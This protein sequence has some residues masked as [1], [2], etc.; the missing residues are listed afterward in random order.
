VE[1]LQA[2]PSHASSKGSG[3]AEPGA[4]EPGVAEPGV[5]EPGLAEHGVAEH[6]ARGH[7]A[8]G[9]SASGHSVVEAG[10]SEHSEAEAGSA[11]RPCRSG[12]GAG[13]GAKRSSALLLAVP[14]AAALAVAS[15]PPAAASVVPNGRAMTANVAAPPRVAASTE[16]AS[17]EVASTEVAST[18]VGSTEVA[19]TEVGSAVAAS[20]C[21]LPV[22]S[23]PYDGFKVGVPGGWDVSSLQ[24]LIG[25]TA[26]AA[27]TEGALLYPALLTSGVTTHSL[28]SSF[29][30]YEDK[31]LGKQ[32]ASLTYSEHP[33]AQP[34]ASL[35]IRAGGTVLAGR[36]GVLVL[37]LRTQVTDKLG[38]AYAYWAPQAQLAAAAPTLSEIASCYQPEQ[39][40][41]FQLFRNVGAFTFTMPPGWR[42]SSLNQNFIQL[43]G[44]GTGAGVT[45][46]LWGPFEQGVNATQPIT[47]VGSA[48]SYMFNLYGIKVNQ[49]LSSYVLPGQATEYMEFVG[50]LNGKAIHGIVNMVASIDGPSAAGVI[51]LGLATPALWNSVN[52]GLVQMMG[53]I[54]HNFSGDLQQIAQLNRQ[55]QD[56][57]GQVSDFD[58]ILN[59][60][61]LVQDPTNG[62]LY[63]APYSAWD[64]EGPNGPGYYLANG[65]QL[66]PVQRP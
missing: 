39:A 2:T 52:G 42:V 65:Q 48:I 4:A 45:Y 20:N 17:T 61:Q 7:S 22:A 66:N 54:Q 30:G 37:P 47:S 63:E 3:Q 16:V 18:E 8:S 33:G 19:S 25:V 38:V 40:D 59:N 10:P 29:L 58:D 36:A 49:V 6:S 44:F 5:A 51:R 23:D 60:Q 21:H 46:E 35:E 31:T 53:S 57:S 32:G 12:R 55:W 41:L 34:A 28:L 24:G 14:L 64:Q 26:N 9:H 43:N 56:F 62:N 11:C 1:I 27:G 13:R 50:T 15:A